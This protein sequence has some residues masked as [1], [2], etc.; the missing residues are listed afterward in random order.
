MVE[1]VILDNFL[2]WKLPDNH[3]FC[4]ELFRFGALCLWVYYL[5]Q[6]YPVTYFQESIFCKTLKNDTFNSKTVVVNMRLLCEKISA[7]KMSEWRMGS[8][9]AGG[10]QKL[11]RLGHF[12]A[13][14]D[15]LSFKVYSSANLCIFWVGWKLEKKRYVIQCFKYKHSFGNHFIPLQ[16]KTLISKAIF[17]KTSFK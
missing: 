6:H 9:I 15:L 13:L 10:K 12:F 16:I 7:Q 2:V 11:A 8:H 4:K 14:E 5:T 3:N 17:W 1:I